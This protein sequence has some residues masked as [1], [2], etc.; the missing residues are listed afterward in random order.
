MI[1]IIGATGHL[2]GHVAWQLL[3]QGHPVRAMTRE[4]TRAHAL[5]SAGAK[6]VRGDLRDPD[7]LRA[8]MRGVQAVVSASHA[9]LGAGKSSSARVDDEGQRALIDAAKDAG[10]AHFLFTSVL[11][12]S[13]TH[14]VDFWRTKERIE[15]YLIASGLAYTI[16]RPAAFMEVHA[17]DLIGKAVLAGK[18]V[19]LFGPGTSP[20][21]FVAASDV[22]ALIVMALEDERLRDTTIEIGGP[23]NLSSRQV[24]AVFESVTGKTAKVVHLTLP[25]LRVV[26]RLLAPLHQGVSRI[27]QAAIVGETTDQRFDPAPLLA[28]IPVKLTRLEDWARANVGH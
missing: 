4:P 26:S 8:A 6:V 16:I 12:A 14:P 13:A 22:A 23:E 15:R 25:M 21:N 20:K 5:Q 17:Y 2:G 3:A 7:S 28:R 18:P 1:L 19:V 10:V 9:M 24:V 27:L 11:G